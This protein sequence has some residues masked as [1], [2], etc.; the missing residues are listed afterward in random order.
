MKKERIFIYSER[1][2]E[3][4]ECRLCF[5]KGKQNMKNSLLPSETYSVTYKNSANQLML[6]IS[7]NY[8]HF[9]Y[10]FIVI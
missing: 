1:E 7:I 3:Q 6:F 8:Y 9:Y 10:L 4:Q 2:I 5:E